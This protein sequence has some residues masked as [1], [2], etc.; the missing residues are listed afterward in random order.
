MESVTDNT[1]N[2]ASLLSNETE[3]AMAAWAISPYPGLSLK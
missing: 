3:I 1:I 2:I